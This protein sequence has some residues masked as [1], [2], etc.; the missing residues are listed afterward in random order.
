MFY[1]S[2]SLKIKWNANNEVTMYE[3]TMID[4]IEEMEQQETVI[5]PLQII[6]TLYAK[7]PLKPDSRITQ[8][9]LGYSTLVKLTR[10]QVLVPTWE[11]QVKLSDGTKESTL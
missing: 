2:G 8:M 10:T 11:V 7:G 4:N 6:Q 1:Y 3:Q 9:K 5:P